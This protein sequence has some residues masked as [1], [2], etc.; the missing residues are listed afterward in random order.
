M[1]KQTA[2]RGCGVWYGLHGLQGLL[3]SPPV[4]NPRNVIDYGLYVRHYKVGNPADSAIV[5]AAAEGRPPDTCWTAQVR[6]W[7]SGRCC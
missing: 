5:F 1:L 6:C 7:C 4:D 3:L 2:G